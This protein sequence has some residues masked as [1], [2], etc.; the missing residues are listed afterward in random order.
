MYHKFYVVVDEP[1]YKQ[2]IHDELMA[3]VGDETVPNRPVD[4]HD[5]MPHSEYNGLFYL[6]QDEADALMS[7]L[8]VAHVHRIP[9]ELGVKKSITGARL[10]TYSKF[11]TH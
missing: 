10:G 2:E 4:A 11:R 6:T 5:L 1:K 9:E 3:P 7:D 8:R